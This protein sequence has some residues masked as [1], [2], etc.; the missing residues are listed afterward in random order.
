MAG[1]LALLYVMFSVFLSLSHNGVLGQ[2]WYLIVSIPDLCNVLYFHSLSLNGTCWV[3]LA[4]FATF[5][6]VKYKRKIFFGKHPFFVFLPACVPCLFPTTPF[7]L[8]VRLIV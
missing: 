1:L 3:L 8:S 7:C 4:L 2:V 6:T 5:L